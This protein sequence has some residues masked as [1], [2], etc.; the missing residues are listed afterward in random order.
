MGEDFDEID[1]SVDSRIVVAVVGFRFVADSTAT[2]G[3]PFFVDSTCFGLFGVV[4]TGIR[5]VPSP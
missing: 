1:V 2:G 5:F 4:S 3:G